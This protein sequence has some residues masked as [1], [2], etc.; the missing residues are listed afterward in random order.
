MVCDSKKYHYGYCHECILRVYS[1][2]QNFQKHHY[3]D[4]IKVFQKSLKKLS[5][6]LVP[7]SCTEDI[8]LNESMFI[9]EPC[10][11]KR[12]N[13]VIKSCPHCGIKSIKPSACNF[14]RCSCGNFWCFVCNVRL[15]GT[16]EGHNKHFWIGL[17]S[18]PYDD[19]CRVSKEFDGPNHILQDS[20]CSYCLERNCSPMC[21]TIDCQRG[22]VKQNRSDLE[23][24]LY[25]Q[26]CGVCK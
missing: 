18:S 14:V 21:M 5:I 22:T 23:G 16:H 2:R 7:K 12:D 9:C 1:S 10:K 25:N 17:G 8:E 20:E 26:Y 11:D 3:N 13:V 4:N 6:V 24:L 15:P 19:N